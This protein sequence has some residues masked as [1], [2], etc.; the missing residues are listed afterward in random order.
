MENIATSQEFSELADAYQAGMEKCVSSGYEEFGDKFVRERKMIV[1][2][3]RAA[4][5][6][7]ALAELPRA[8]VPR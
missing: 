3:L 5:S 8:S 4:A 1:A 7:R 2:A 6:L